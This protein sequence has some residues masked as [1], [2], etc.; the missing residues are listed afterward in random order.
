MASERCLKNKQKNHHHHQVLVFNHHLKRLLF[1]LPL[2]GVI[3]LE[4]SANLLFIDQVKIIQMIAPCLL[5]QVKII[6]GD[7]LFGRNA[8]HLKGRFEGACLCSTL[9]HHPRFAPIRAPRAQIAMY[10]IHWPKAPKC[11]GPDV[12]VLGGPR[13]SSPL[14]IHDEKI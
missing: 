11:S 12:V 13:S 3:D 14:K 8:K 4:Q 7:M 1:K 10:S 9:F 6:L 5:S 2:T